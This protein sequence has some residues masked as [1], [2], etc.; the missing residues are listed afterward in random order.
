MT[1]AQRLQVE[2]SEKRQKINELLAA[3]DIGDEQRTELGTLTGR[4]QEIEVELRAAIVAESA[5]EETRLQTEPDSELRERRALRE[6]ASLL[7]FLQAALAGRRVDG[8][9]A[10]LQA[11]AEVRDGIPLELWDVPRQVEQRQQAEQRVDVV[12]SAVGTVGVNL[13]AIR[14]AVFANSIAPRLGV[15]MPRVESGSY[16][17][18][19]IATSLTASAQPKSGEA[20]ATAAAF[21]AQTMTPKRISARLAIAIEDVA[22]VGTANF[23]SILREN[24]S[25][26]L[27]DALDSSMI[28]GDGSSNTLVG[29][30]HRLTDPTAA[31]SAISTFDDFAS[32]H[33]GAIDGLWASTLM[34]V[35]IVAGPSTYALAARTFQTATN[36]KGEMSAAAYAAKMTGGFWTNK[37]MPD[38]ATFMSVDDVQQAIVYRKARSMMG[39]SGGMR[40]AV[41]PTWNVISID[42]ILSGSASGERFFTLHVLLGDV[43]LVQ[44]DAYQQIAY[45]VA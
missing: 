37:R 19:T 31:P 8:A 6:K 22:S 11:A 23:E 20:M 21:T 26:V 5:A 14:P 12:T 1:P 10:E 3:D 33:A 42:D 29:V 16:V 34:D 2:Q 28:N 7:N 38:A 24:L 13:D 17:S 4:M 45:K 30:L 43:V 36:Y 9:E 25:L 41:C 27:S 18:A 40:T 15:E 32:S 39:G 35:G 44:P